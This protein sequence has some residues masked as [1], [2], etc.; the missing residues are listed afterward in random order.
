MEGGREPGRPENC[1][2]G[3]G[4]GGGWRNGVP[5]RALCFVYERMFGA[6]GAGTQNFGPKKFFPPIISPPPTFE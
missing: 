2:A 5:C 1:S 4:G 6:E 3:G